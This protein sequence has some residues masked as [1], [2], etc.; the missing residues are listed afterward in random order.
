AT[1]LI[2]S[3][4]QSY[5]GERSKQVLAQTTQAIYEGAIQTAL[6]L[7]QSSQDTRYL[8]Q[9]FQ[10][11]ESNKAI[12][13]LESMN[14]NW[15]KG[16]GGIPNEL[17]QQEKALRIDIA[18][19]EKT[20][21]E[22]KQKGKSA[23]KAKI[24]SWE[25]QWF[26]SKNQYQEL[27]ADFEQNYPKY[28]QLKY[29]TDLIT[30]AEVQ[31]QLLTPQSALLEYFLGEEE[32]YLFCISQSGIQ[33]WAQPWDALTQQHL[34]GLRD[35]L[36]YPPQSANFKTQFEQFNQQ[37]N[38]LYELLLAQPLATLDSAVQ[39]LII[40]PDGQLAYLPFD[41][42]LTSPSTTTTV[43]YRPEALAYLFEDFS[44][45]YSYSS[46][47]L[48]QNTH[49]PKESAPKNL[50]AYAPSFHSLVVGSR[51]ACTFNELYSLRCNQ[52]EVK[53]ICQLFDGKAQLATK[54]N[55][56]TFAAE[57]KQYQVIHLATHACADEADARLNRIFFTDD[58][59]SSN[60]LYNLQLQ[61]DLVVLSA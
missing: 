10:F 41:L 12:L 20:I 8:N 29:Q 47:L 50:V 38:A 3:I 27:I 26:S 31:E 59:L 54:A 48:Q 34:Q 32:V 36:Q 23:D 45:S 4:R 46:T 61:A 9:A 43:N 6:Q 53:S 51:E 2:R 25:K 18:F 16:V 7:H 42:L 21:R 17:L 56:S 1:D 44:I 52:G 58:Y 22:E 13:L 60:D 24:K 57:A 5:Q 19:Y 30:V 49:R 15:A 55:K 14:D 35:I 40:V 39:Q 28:H 37:A 33:L 11:A